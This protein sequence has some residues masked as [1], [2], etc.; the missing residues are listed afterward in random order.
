MSPEGGGV[1]VGGGGAILM[2]IG[3]EVGRGK[4]TDGSGYLIYRVGQ[5][6][7]RKFPHNSI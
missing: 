4:G 3:W 7:L 6:F 1:W 5:L 2:S